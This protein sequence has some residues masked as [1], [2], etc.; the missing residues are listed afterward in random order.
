MSKLIRRIEDSKLHGYEDRIAKLSTVIDCLEDLQIAL[1]RAQIYTSPDE[2]LSIS[3]LY[4]TALDLLKELKESTIAEMTQAKDDA[5]VDNS[6]EEVEEGLKKI[7]NQADS[8][9]DK[10]RRRN[11]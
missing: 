5:I 4:L 6:L 9:R 1:N 11:E 3:E 10:L 8:L 2:P 7:A